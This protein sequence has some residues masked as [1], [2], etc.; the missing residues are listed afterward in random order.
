VHALFVNRDPD[1]VPVL[2]DDLPSGLRNE[3]AALDLSRRDLTRL[4]A[5]LI[6]IHGRS[7][8]LVPY[9]E[10]LALARSAGP[11]GSRLYLLDDLDHVDLGAPGLGDLAT[12]LRATYRILA[13]R[14]AAPRPAGPVSLRIGARQSL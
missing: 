10:S 5:S 3:I 13:E 2:V 7:D 9:T 14:D 11:A 8:P 12:L 1:R 4:G 6:L